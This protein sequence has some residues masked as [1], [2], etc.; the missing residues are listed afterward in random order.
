MLHGLIVARNSFPE[1]GLDRDTCRPVIGPVVTSHVE[2]A[3]RAKWPPFA[4]VL[5]ALLGTLVVG[6]IYLEDNPEVPA[7]A[8]R[9]TAATTA[10][11]PLS[12]LPSISVPIASSAPIAPSSIEPAPSAAPPVAEGKG[13][14]KIGG[15]KDAR[16]YDGDAFVGLAPMLYPA[17]AG[18]HTIRVE[19]PFV[20]SKQ[21]F[22]VEVRAG[23]TTPV[24]V[25]FDPKK[26]RTKRKPQ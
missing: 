25:D 9:S 7:A 1:S 2:P 15:P 3:Q 6:F 8:R 21:T 12:A 4:V 19:H 14:I 26:A 16:I 11:T 5:G 18:D 20:A 17:S 24:V 23:K 13:F 22:S 10:T